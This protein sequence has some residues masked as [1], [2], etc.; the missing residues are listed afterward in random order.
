MT[1]NDVLRRLRYV[2]NYT[3]AAMIKIFA[4]A[5]VKVAQEQVTARLKKDDAERY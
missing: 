2:F 4:Q 5:D 1:N 3:D